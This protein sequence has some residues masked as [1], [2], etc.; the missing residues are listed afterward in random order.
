MRNSRAIHLTR[1]PDALRQRLH[2]RVAEQRKTF[3]LVAH[4]P[5]LLDDMFGGVQTPRI[6]WRREHSSFTSRTCDQPEFGGNKRGRRHHV[7]LA[8]LVGSLTHNEAALGRI[9]AVIED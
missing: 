9:A 5:K 6:A 7:E 2:R 3:R 4:R 8:P 1:A